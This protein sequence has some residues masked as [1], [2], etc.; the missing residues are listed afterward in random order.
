MIFR[1]VRKL[2]SLYIEVDIRNAAVSHVMFTEMRVS[3]KVQLR[4][5][6]GV[7]LWTWNVRIWWSVKVALR[8]L[9]L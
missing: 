3:N 6:R 7:I 8:L 4:V 1:I 5:S 9:Q 2:S